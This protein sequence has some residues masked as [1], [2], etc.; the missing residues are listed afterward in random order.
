M[1][2]RK[3]EKNFLVMRTLRNHSVNNFPMYHMVVLIIVVMLYI[4]ALVLIYP[5]T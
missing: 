5:K 3:K 1:K 4:T 2:E